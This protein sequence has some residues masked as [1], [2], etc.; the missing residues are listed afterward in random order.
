VGRG[1][2][3][4]CA[5]FVAGAA[6]MVG[7]F[8]T[9]RSDLV[10][11]SGGGVL[12]AVLW[13][14]GRVAF[15]AR[16]ATAPWPVLFHVLLAFAN[17][18]AAAAFGVALG[19]DR[20]HGTFG[21][22]PVAAVFAHV[23]LAAIGWPVMMVVGLAYR[24]VPMFLPAKMPTGSGLALSAVLLE[25]GIGVIVV[26]L[27]TAS[28]WLPMGA[29]LIAAG[30]A[31]FVR[32]MRAAVKHK[33]PRPPALPSRDWSTWQTHVAIAWLFVAAGLGVALTWP[34]PSPRIGMAW[35]YGVAGLVGFLAQVVVG[36]QGRLVPLYA[37]Y[38]A[39]TALAGSPPSRAANQ[40]PTAA[41]AR[42][43]FLLW[44]VG[45]PALAW[46]LATSHVGV[47]RLASLVL[48]AGVMTGGAYLAYLVRMAGRPAGRSSI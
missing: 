15:G 22:P 8:W 47:V 6:G 5:G 1:D 21:F 27:L 48:L 44:T 29:A 28:A 26:T 25:F 30:L 17:M 3:L 35:V 20:A 38:R 4:A 33:L 19:I 9:G 45:V 18:L 40:L 7:H 46:G 24:L 31:C 39:M 2:W 12:M 37:Y 34:S 16:R 32:N 43:I 42:P 41:Y 14:A 13:L 23:H 11:W 10:A 36:I